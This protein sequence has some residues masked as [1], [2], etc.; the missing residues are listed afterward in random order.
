MRAAVLSLALLLPCGADPAACVV[1]PDT[2]PEELQAR[3]HDQH[4]FAPGGRAYRVRPV[5]AA[6][7]FAPLG[8]YSDHLA[9]EV[10]YEI[11]W[12]RQAGGQFPSLTP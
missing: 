2:D 6:R 11:G 3:T 1:P 10:T 8:E 9:Y 5:S 4:F 12:Q 7:N